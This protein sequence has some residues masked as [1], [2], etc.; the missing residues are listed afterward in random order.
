MPG[1]SSGRNFVWLPCLHPAPGFGIWISQSKDRSERTVDREKA[2][3]VTTHPWHPG[4]GTATDVWGA[5]LRIPMQ[6]GSPL[7][8]FS[9]LASRPHSVS[10]FSLEAVDHFPP[11]TEWQ[12][13]L[14]PIFIQYCLLWNLV[15]SFPTSYT[16]PV[17]CRHRCC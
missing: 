14:V 9:P 10:A 17:K 13:V 3:Q 8:H 4:D 2:Q 7:T 6:L 16:A 11:T 15:I 5:G 12:N 1:A